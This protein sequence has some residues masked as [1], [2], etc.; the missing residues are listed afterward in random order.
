[1]AL[2][3]VLFRTY[4]GRLKSTCTRLINPSRNFVE[5]RWREVP[6]F[7]S[8]ALLTTLHPLL[9]NVLQTVNHFEFLVLELH[10]HGWKSP[11]IAW[12]R[13]LNWILCS[14][15]KK[16]IGRTPLEHP[17][18]SPGII[19]P[20]SLPFTTIDYNFSA[21]SGFRCVTIQFEEMSYITTCQWKSPQTA[22]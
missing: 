14:A 16:G 7:A 11:E 19:L 5:V 8:D 12:G 4:G 18:Y 22:L 21:W 3:T 1:M 9:E 20:L 6:P 10:F 2:L 17:P 13:G 15:W